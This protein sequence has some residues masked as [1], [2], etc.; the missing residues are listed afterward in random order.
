MG[1]AF[2]IRWLAALVLVLVTYNPT[3]WNFISWARSD[4]QGNLPVL[5]L[6]G[7]V[8]LVAYVVYFRAT[9]R[10]I[11]FIGI[12]LV[13]ALFAAIIWVLWDW[14]L[15]SLDNAS[16]LTW[17]GLVMLSLVMGVGLSWSIIRRRLSG[18]MDVDDVET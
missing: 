4:Y 1:N 12:G 10:S 5:A 18:Q 17:I 11:G 6:L 16:L 2:L 9:F 14:G 7:L 8:L 13:V 15:L 3:S